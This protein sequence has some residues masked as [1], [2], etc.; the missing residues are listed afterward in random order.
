ML[1]TF[2]KKNTSPFSMYQKQIGIQMFIW[3]TLLFSVFF[4]IIQELKTMLNESNEFKML[5]NT[6]NMAS[7][8][9][10]KK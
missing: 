8:I 6:D 5:L 3:K 10:N 7:L 2:I 1:F 9:F 4:K